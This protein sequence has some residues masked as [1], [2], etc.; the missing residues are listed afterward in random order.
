ML[1][2]S[3]HIS[4]YS[5]LTM[6]TSPQIN[7]AADGPAPPRG[8]AGDNGDQKYTFEGHSPAPPPRNPEA[9]HTPRTPRTPRNGHTPRLMNGEASPRV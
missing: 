1:A 2:F 4:R 3:S 5:P 6:I 8:G 9:P 7:G